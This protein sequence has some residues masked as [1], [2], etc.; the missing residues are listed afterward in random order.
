MWMNV[1]KEPCVE[2]GGRVAQ[3]VLYNLSTMSP[4]LKA[5]NTAHLSLQ[6]D[7]KLYFFIIGKSN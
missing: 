1:Y 2:G 3:V 6:T 5:H 7:V 4:V